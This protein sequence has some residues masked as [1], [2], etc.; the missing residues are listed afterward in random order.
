LAQKQ[1]DRT[2]AARDNTSIAYDLAGTALHNA[3]HCGQVVLLRRVQ[4]LW[5]PAGGD[6]NDF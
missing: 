5:P 6:P 1:A 2:S 3:Y 4:G